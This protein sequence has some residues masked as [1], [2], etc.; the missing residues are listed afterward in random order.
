MLYNSIQV[1]FQTKAVYF[2]W[3]MCNTHRGGQVRILVYALYPLFFLDECHDCRTEGHLRSNRMTSSHYW[4][5]LG[6]RVTNPYRHVLLYRPT[7]VDH[8]HPQSDY[9]LQIKE[10]KKHILLPCIP[11]TGTSKCIFPIVDYLLSIYSLC[12][13]I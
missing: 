4:I 3:K 8:V 13:K 9:M 7:S 12:S 6:P 1:N 10:E 5:C 11:H 2:V